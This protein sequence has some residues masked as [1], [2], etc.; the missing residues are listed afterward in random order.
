MGF[1]CGIIGLPNVGKSTLFNALTHASVGAENFPFCT[2]EPN[3]GAVP[4]P[5]PRLQRIADIVRPQRTVPTLTEFV[6]I[7]GLV[8]GASKGEGLG[9]KFLANIRSTDAIV[10]VVRCH[11]DAD[12]THVSGGIS[13][14]ADVETINTEL[15]LADLD[16]IATRLRKLEPLASSGDKRAAASLAL[17][18]RV[19]E[20]L[21]EGRPARAANFNATELRELAD[22]QLL[23]LKPVLY[24][25]NIAEDAADSKALVEELRQA[26][27]VEGAAVLCLCAKLEAELAEL[28]EAESAEMLEAMGLEEPGL[29][30][31]IRA[32][33]SL[34]DLLTFFTAGPKEARAWTLRTGSAAPQAGGRIHGDF[35]KGFIRAEVIAYED[36]VAC[37]GEHGAREAGKWRLEGKEYIVC[38]GDVMHFRFSV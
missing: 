35:E 11:E 26:V 9:N 29:A 38:D 20:G 10:H 2:I 25:A 3:I 18:R 23:T 24:L 8:A 15:M 19:E 27:A 13:P 17:L 4:V 1:N 34:L 30:K 21:N 12:I 31:L 22:C 14:A 28:A 37:N 6:D 7:A 33:Y 32:G 5:D 36:F 16:G